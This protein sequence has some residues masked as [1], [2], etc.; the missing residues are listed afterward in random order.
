MTRA[1]DR[2]GHSVGWMKTS[3]KAQPSV[4]ELRQVL[5]HHGLHA[6]FKPLWGR[7]PFNNWLVIARRSVSLVQSSRGRFDSVRQQA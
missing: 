7:T 3:F 6:E 1:T 4:Q 5:Q 2:F